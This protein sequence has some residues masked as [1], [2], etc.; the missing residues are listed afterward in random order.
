[1]RREVGLQ[2]IERASARVRTPALAVAEGAKKEFRELARRQRSGAV[3]PDRTPALGHQRKRRIVGKEPR[4]AGPLEGDPLSLAGRLAWDGPID[5]FAS[6]LYLP[7]PRAAVPASRACVEE[8]V[9][10]GP[11]F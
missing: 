3:P 7:Q 9:M 4:H 6:W 11:P 1:M 2:R 5:A 10:A 8:Q